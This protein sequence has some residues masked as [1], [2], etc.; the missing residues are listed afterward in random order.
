MKTPGRCAAKQ[1][2]I[3]AWKR[4]YGDLVLTFAEIGKLLNPRFNDLTNK[5]FG[6]LRVV[7]YAGRAN[8]GRRDDGVC[9]AIRSW[10]DAER[11]R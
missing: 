9:A 4:E 11:R 8:G 10:A 5:I 1:S 6:K 2:R 7:A 3:P